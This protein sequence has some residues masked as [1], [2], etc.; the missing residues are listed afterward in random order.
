MVV[1]GNHQNAAMRRGPIGV[2]VFQRVARSIDAGS[3]AVPQREHALHPSIR[4]GLHLLRAQHRG[5]GEIFVNRR[6]ELDAVCL[7][8]RLD[9][10]KLEIN[11]CKRRAAIAGDEA[12]GVEPRRAIASCL[13]EQDA[14]DGLRSRQ[15]DA[16]VFAVVAIGQLIGVEGG[17]GVHRRPPRVGIAVERRLRYCR[18]PAGAAN[19]LRQ[20]HKCLIA[21]RPRSG[22]A[23]FRSPQ[24]QSRPRRQS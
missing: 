4:L 24:F 8:P 21:S 9:T 11:A 5:C 16:A 1:A 14:D 2:A 20:A 7:Q 6:Q 10:P 13:I 3:L 18:T 15:E 22:C 23:R 17:N 12:G 19:L